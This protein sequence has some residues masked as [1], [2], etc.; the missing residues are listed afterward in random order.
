MPKDV[1]LEDL[2]DIHKKIN[3]EIDRLK[4]SRDSLF[5]SFKNFEEWEKKS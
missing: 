2:R 5:E 4:T 3:K 1:K